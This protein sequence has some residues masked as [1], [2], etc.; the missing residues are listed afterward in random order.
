MSPCV[1]V[2][3]TP[4]SLNALG[5]SPLFFIERQASGARRLGRVPLEAHVG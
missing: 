3:I 2:C 1:L 5:S 4:Y